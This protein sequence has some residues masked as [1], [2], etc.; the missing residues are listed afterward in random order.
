MWGLPML[1]G[2]ERLGRVEVRVVIPARVA[3]REPG[4]HLRDA[5]RKLVQSRTLLVLLQRVAELCAEC[6][7]DDVPGQTQDRS[8]VGQ[9]FGG[10][11]DLLGK[12]GVSVLS[13]RPKSS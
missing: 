3:E 12:P 2:E 7:V 6:L 4:G 1:P 11:G 10:I 13:V 8:R 5:R 9:L